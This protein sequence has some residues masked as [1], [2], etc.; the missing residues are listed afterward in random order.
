MSRLAV[1]TGASRGLGRAIVDELS[2][3]GWAV[4]A[5]T[6]ENVSNSAWPDNVNVVA[7]DIGQDAAVPAL[8]SVL[9]EQP[10]DLIVNN[11]AVGAPRVGIDSAQAD[12]MLNAMNVNVVGPFR[13]I[14]GLLPNLRRAPHPM[15]VN[16]SSR[17]ASLSAQARGDFVQIDSSYA[18]RVSKAAQNMLTIAVAN[19]LAGQ[20]RCCAVHPGA[21]MTDM[22]LADA[23]KPPQQAARELLELVDSPRDESP[24]F[25]SLGAADLE[26]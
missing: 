14:K 17:L 18:Y 20:V 7:A 4:V 1:V 2:A 12:E 5:V 19:E 21:L 3:A 26:W 8:L 6:R 9:G 25:N 24:S 23:S 15:I 16:I 10:L 11:A 22:A 13:V